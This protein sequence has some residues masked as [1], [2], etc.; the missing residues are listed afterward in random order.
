MSHFM[1]FNL[2][3]IQT[4]DNKKFPF[5]PCSVLTCFLDKPVGRIQMWLLCLW[6]SKRQ[7][8]FSL[9]YKSSFHLFFQ[10]FTVHCLELGRC[11][12]SYQDVHTSSWSR[13]TLE[14]L[15][16]CLLPTPPD[17]LQSNTNFQYFFPPGTFPSG[18]IFYQPGSSWALDMA[19]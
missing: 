2:G 13:H 6:L 5:A 1:Y 15:S 16:L 11:F 4:T 9:T 17:H 12:C 10:T 19:E 8:S 7:H 14:A 18:G 3:N